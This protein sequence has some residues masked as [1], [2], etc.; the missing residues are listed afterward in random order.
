ME[1]RLRVMPRTIF[2]SGLAS[3]QEDAEVNLSREQRI[4]DSEWGET[5]GPSAFPRTLEWEFAT[6]AIIINTRINSTILF[7]QKYRMA[8]LNT[9]PAVL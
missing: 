1:E 6:N 3:F 8:H 4:S 2:F 5:A 7:D 9:T